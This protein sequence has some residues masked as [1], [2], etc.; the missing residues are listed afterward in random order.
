MGVSSLAALLARFFHIPAGFTDFGKVCLD[1]FICR[2]KGCRGEVGDMG[3]GEDGKDG[4]EGGRGRE[5]EEGFESI[6][7]RPLLFYYERNLSAFRTG[8]CDLSPRL[9]CSIR[10]HG[11]V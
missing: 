2:W 1:R 9:R 11:I 6:M 3:D 7:L 5:R 8:G 10:I 4:E